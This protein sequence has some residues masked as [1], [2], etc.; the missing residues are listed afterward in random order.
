MYHQARIEATSRILSRSPV[1]KLVVN[2]YIQ[3]YCSMKGLLSDSLMQASVHD[4]DSVAC[5]CCGCTD[6]YELNAH[7]TVIGRLSAQHAM[8]RRDSAQRL[9]KTNVAQHASRECDF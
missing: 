1:V 5:R 3:Q 6:R 2:Y 4:S 9:V 8:A 7:E